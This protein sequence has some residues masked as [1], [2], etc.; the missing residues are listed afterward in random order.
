MSKD[1]ER[2][3]ES[4]VFHSVKVVT[5]GYVLFGPF[6]VPFLPR[7]IMGRKKPWHDINDPEARLRDFDDDPRLFFNIRRLW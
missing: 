3:L 2:P 4:Q 7:P 5:S 6:S 1:S